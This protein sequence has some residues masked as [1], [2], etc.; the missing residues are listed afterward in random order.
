VP[1]D[2]VSAWDA[3]TI[4]CVTASHRE[5]ANPLAVAGTLGILSGI[6]Y[7]AQ[8]MA[9]H[10]GLTVTAGRRP[11]SGYL[12]SVRALIATVARLDDRPGNLTIEAKLLM[13][14]G[15]RVSYGFTLFSGGEL[16]LTGRAA[17]VLD[18]AE[19]SGERP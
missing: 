7:A 15:F 11:K 16:L 10:G 3:N 14:E 18:A 5:T 19:P 2:R 12:A 9:I 4:C 8:A 6:E 1:D 13:R 17:V